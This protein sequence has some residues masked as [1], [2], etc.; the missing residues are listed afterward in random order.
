MTRK[1]IFKDERIEFAKQKIYSEMLIIIY[2]IAVI[3][4]CVKVLFFNMSLAAC[5]TEYVILIFTPIYQT[6]RARALQVVLMPEGKSYTGWRLLL[7]LLI[8]VSLFCFVAYRN[9]GFSDGSFNGP[10]ASIIAFI[11]AFV[12][13]RVLFVHL[14]SKRRRKLE[15]DYTDD[16]EK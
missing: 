6:I 4:F 9:G 13:I 1:P 2:Y 15:S 11:I 3:S 16:T 10:I 8:A 14:E 5:T 7:P 12:V